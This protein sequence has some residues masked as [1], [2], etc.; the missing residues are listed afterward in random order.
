MAELIK[1]IVDNGISV[2]CVAYL[3]IFSFTTMKDIS[4]SLSEITTTLEVMKE[5][6]KDLKKTKNKSKKKEDEE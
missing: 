2:V 3:I 4:K 6:I 5:E 1:L